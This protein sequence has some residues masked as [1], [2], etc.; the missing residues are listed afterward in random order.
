MAIE[1]SACTPSFGISRGI[2]IRFGA[3]RREIVAG[4]KAGESHAGARCD[5]SLRPAGSKA[6][7]FRA[8]RTVFRKNYPF[9]S[10]GHLGD[11]LLLDARKT[12]SG[13]GG[14]RLTCA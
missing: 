10:S 8:P 9:R 11:S 2:R 12:G 14:G 7:I 13:A 5:H 1:G 4:E 6:A 3:Q